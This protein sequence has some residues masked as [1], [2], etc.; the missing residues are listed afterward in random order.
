MQHI[1]K[2]MQ[3][4]YKQIDV[5][6]FFGGAQCIF[7]HIHIE[8][9]W[10]RCEKLT[11]TK[12]DLNWVRYKKKTQQIY[13]HINITHFFDGYIAFFAYTYLEIL[14]KMRKANHIVTRLG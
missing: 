13:K 8:K 3:H 10:K 11:T 5:A 2:K 6:H 1:L 14:E 4:I 7:S 12:L 9:F